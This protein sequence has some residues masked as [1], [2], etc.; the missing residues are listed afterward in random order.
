M[1]A[2]ARD[3]DEVIAIAK[4][5]SDLVLAIYQRPF[6]V[7]M[8]GRNDPVTEADRAANELISEALAKVFPGDAIVA[9]ESAPAT[10][11][12][13]RA[14]VSKERVFYVDPVDGTREFVD[15]NGEFAVMIGLSIHGRAALGVVVRPTEGTVFAGIVGGEAFVESA[16]GARSKLR[17]SD[18]SDPSMA[19]LMVSRSHLPKLVAPFVSALG[20]KRQLPCG[21]VGVKVSKVVTGEADLYVHGGLGAK[22]WDTAAP[23]AILVAAGGRFSDLSGEPID[24]ASAELRLLN[25]LV[26]SNAALYG[27]AIEALARARLR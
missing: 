3:L 13:A 19:T 22:R 26:A 1:S 21:S 20:I 15:K 18:V 8:K 25:G 14:L 11:H 24:Y 7:A 17:V 6:S 5:A 9:E 2:L 27:R 10:E 16:S 12:E 23:E 4:R